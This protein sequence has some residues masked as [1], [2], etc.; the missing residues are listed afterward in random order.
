[1]PTYE[2]ACREFFSLQFGPIFN[3]AQVEHLLEICKDSDLD[4]D[5]EITKILKTAEA[6]G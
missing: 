4:I 1:M 2:Q 5:A 3:P 6:Q